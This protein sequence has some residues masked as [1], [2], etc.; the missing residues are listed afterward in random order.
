MSRANSLK[1]AI[2]QIIEQT[3]KG[4]SE[5]IS[6]DYYSTLCANNRM[7]CC[8]VGLQLTLI[9]F[10]LL[11]RKKFRHSDVCMYVCVT[12]YGVVI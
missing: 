12:I 5:H 2:R 1:K 9:I 6:I 4:K 11:N 7:N 3:E 10:V 8:K